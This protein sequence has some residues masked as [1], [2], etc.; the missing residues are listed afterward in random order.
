[1]ILIWEWKDCRSRGEWNSIRTA[2]EELA[3]GL[4]EQESR[5]VWD[6]AGKQ[7][8]KEKKSS[9]GRSD[10]SMDKEMEDC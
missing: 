5:Y 2:I 8:A 7:D 10:Q 3:W 1:M 6:K 4:V 9:E